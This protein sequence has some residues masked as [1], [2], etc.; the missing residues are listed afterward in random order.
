[1][2]PAPYLRLNNPTSLSRNK[3]TYLLFCKY[4]IIQFKLVGRNE[5]GEITLGGG[6]DYVTASYAGVA[7]PSL[8]EKEQKFVP[9]S[10]IHNPPLLSLFTLLSLSRNNST[11][12]STEIES[13][14]ETSSL[15]P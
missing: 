7:G 6:M 2:V 4:T 15:I 3:F 9:F 14:G 8:T 12:F 11:V 10:F 1:M 13:R 5:G